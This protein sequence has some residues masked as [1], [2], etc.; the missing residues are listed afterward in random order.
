[1]RTGRPISN[2]MKT[3]PAIYMP[4]IDTA[5]AVAQALQRQPRGAGRIR[6][7]EPA[8]HGGAQ[9]A[10]RFDDEIVPLTTRRSGQGNQRGDLPGGPL[11]KDEGNRRTPRWTGSPR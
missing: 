7:A 4:M 11:E 8:A 9:Q 3:Q 6:P 2:A 5:E 10:G 1:M